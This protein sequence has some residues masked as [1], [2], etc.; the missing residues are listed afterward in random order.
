[1]GFGRDGDWRD[2]VADSLGVLIAL[3]ILQAKNAW[4]RRRA[5]GA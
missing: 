5:Q 4:V 3:R 2:F 1:M